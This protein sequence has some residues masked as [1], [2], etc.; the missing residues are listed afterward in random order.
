MD[1][2]QMYPKKY[3]SLPSDCSRKIIKIAAPDISYFI[4]SREK[5][6]ISSLTKSLLLNA[7]LLSEG[8]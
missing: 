5:Y 7:S 4:F 3:F 8:V 2:K 6:K 1:T